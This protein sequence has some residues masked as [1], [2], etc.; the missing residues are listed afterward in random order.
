MPTTLFLI[1][2]GQSLANARNILQGKTVDEALSPLGQQQAAAMARCLKD[3]SLS[4][5]YASGM[6][7]ARETAAPL[8]EARGLTVDPIPELHEIDVGLWA[9]LNWEE[10]RSRWPEELARYQADPA[11][12]GHTG[13]ESYRDVAERVR[14]IFLGLLEKHAGESIAV[15]A[16]NVVNRVYMAD[17]LG[18][19]LGQSPA[20]KQHNGCI[21]II[22]LTPAVTP[23]LSPTAVLP[24]ISVITCNAVLHLEGW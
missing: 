4:R 22:R 10:V 17:L 7:R 9:G 15:V 3:A 2:H 14:P 16:H 23:A 12:Y 24:V 13:G 21:N 19:E 5:V 6:L 20:L 18:L 11:K 8:A 1:R